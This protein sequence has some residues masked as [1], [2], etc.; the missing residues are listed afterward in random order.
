MR[1]MNF[2]RSPFSVTGCCCHG[3]IAETRR[4]RKLDFSWKLQPNRVAS[5]S[6]DAET[7]WWTKARIADGLWRNMDIEHQLDG[8]SEREMG[9]MWIVAGQKFWG[10]FTSFL[11]CSSHPFSCNLSPKSFSVHLMP[12]DGW[13]VMVRRLAGVFVR[14]LM[15]RGRDPASQPVSRSLDDG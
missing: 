2:H 11:G 14:L 8:R 7:H 5:R 13:M 15:T 1:L 3:W 10:I 12:T 6:A 4:R 9:C